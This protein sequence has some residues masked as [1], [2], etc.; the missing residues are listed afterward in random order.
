MANVRAIRVEYTDAA[1]W[2][3]PGSY[4][5]SVYL[6]LRHLLISATRTSLRRVNVTAVQPRWMGLNNL[7]R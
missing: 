1:V 5:G 4:T 6:Y 7:F 2:T 3:S